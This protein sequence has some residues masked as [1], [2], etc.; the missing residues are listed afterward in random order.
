MKTT[1]TKFGRLLVVLSFVFSST[2]LAQD[3]SPLLQDIKVQQPSPTPLV[4]R[5]GSSEP[6]ATS[7]AAVRNPVRTLFPALQ[8][9]EIPGDSG[10]L[11]ESLDGKVVVESNADHM[12]NPA[13]NVKIA[14]AYAVLKTFGPEFR[15]QTNIYTDGSVD[16]QTSTLTGNVYVSGKDPMFANQHAV[17]VASELNRLGIR[18][19]TGNLYVTDNFSINYSQSP[20]SSA[21]AMLNDLDMYKRSPSAT[22][23]WLDQLAYSG[24]AGQ[25]Q[26]TPSVSFTGQPFVTG[27][28]NNL[29]LLFTHESTPMKEIIKATLCYS[30][31]FL[32]AKLGDLLGGPFAVARLV[33]LNANVPPGEF[34]LATSSGLGYNRVT[35]NAMMKLLRALRADLGRYDMTF[36]DIMPVAGIDQG[37]LEERFSADWARGSIVGKTGT[38][39]NTDGGA[40]ALA[41]EA[42]TRNGRLL[43]VIFNMHGSVGRF[44]NFQN[45][46]MPMVQAQFGGAAPMTY[47]AMSVESRLARSRITYPNSVARQGN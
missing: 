9:V 17:A 42:N 35:P 29:R 20:A 22:K 24:Q 21:Q 41:G 39:G 16:P 19:V 36:M 1:F 47:N 30:N 18:F 7:L 3:H 44:R 2:A 10:I 8:Q 34:S 15:F 32:A 14:T 37:T 4:E 46:F 13:S 31:N 25:V 23:A 28:P 11:V 12:F 40:S 5:T 38:L 45:N 6:T 43:F 26:G 33:Q 27:V